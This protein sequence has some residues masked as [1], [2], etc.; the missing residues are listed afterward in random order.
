MRVQIWY[1][2]VAKDSPFYR[3]LLVVLDPPSYRYLENNVAWSD[4]GVSIQIFDRMVDCMLC[5][6]PH[7]LPKDESLDSDFFFL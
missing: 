4:T 1:L 2:V 5:R 3:Y 6:L 7:P